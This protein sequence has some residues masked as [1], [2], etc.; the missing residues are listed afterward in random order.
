MKKNNISEKT[1]QIYF[2]WIAIAIFTIVLLIRLFDLQILHQSE[3]SLQSEQNRVR[4]IPIPT[5]RGQIYDRNM[6]LLVK[7]KRAFSLTVTPIDLQNNLDLY[8]Q[9][10][11]YTGIETDRLQTTVKNNMIGYFNPVKVLRDVE[12]ELVSKFE[13]HRRDFPGVD[14]INESKRAYLEEI[15]ASHLFGYLGEISASELEGD[16]KTF[17]KGDIVGKKG[18]EKWYEN[19]L[20]GEDGFRYVEVDALGR[21]VR[22]LQDPKSENPKPG[23]DLILTIDLELQILAEKLME[24]NRGSLIMMDLSDGGILTLVSKPDYP[25][26]HLSGVISPENWNNLL[27]DPNHPMYDRSIQSV[28][29]PGSTYKMVLA[30]AAISNNTVD[31]N[32]RIHCPGYYQFGR[33]PFKC[34]KGDGHGPVNMYEALEQSC[35]V[36]FWQLGLKVELDEWA[37][38]SKL[39][40]FG[41]TTNIDL[42]SESAGNLPDKNYLDNRY[43]E[44]KWTNGL[45]LNLSVGQGD[46][47]V[48]SL[49]MLQM[50]SIIAKKGVV[51]KPHLLHKT[52]DPLTNEI[53]DSPISTIVTEIPDTAFQVVREGMR[54]V[55]HGSKG[56]GKAAAVPNIV[57]AGKTGTAQNP[58]GENHAWFVGFAPFDSPK[59]AIVV[60]VENGGGGGAVAAPIAGKVLRLYFKN[61]EKKD[62]EQIIA[63]TQN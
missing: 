9:I 47:V 29:P 37:R 41:K 30:L 36:Y 58:H 56:T 5:I 16:Y 32:V 10:S 2:Y 13:E 17:K 60:L 26:E 12:F 6:N 46:L 55:I 31:P 7:N 38:F 53:E 59:V 54:R 49:Q 43:G 40:H 52:R 51:F 45:L 28:F 48:T 27:N 44:G 22:T 25:P 8:D 15:N 18:I 14:F 63:Q 35:N 23:K 24:K 33:R 4:K 57:S 1:L 62:S 11:K 42:P 21:E 34:W 39:L 19:D 20:H 50:T 61:L 3:F